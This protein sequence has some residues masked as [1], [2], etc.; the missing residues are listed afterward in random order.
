MQHLHFSPG[1]EP[2]A[3]LASPRWEQIQAPL[4]A[5]SEI[6]PAGFG[7][8]A[9]LKSSDLELGSG[10]IVSVS[11]PDEENFLDTVPILQ[12]SV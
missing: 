1:V 3:V 2:R 5:Y 7:D 10:I 4:T 12:G 6:L 8:R 11:G 9:F